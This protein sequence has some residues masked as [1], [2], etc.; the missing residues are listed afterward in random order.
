MAANRRKTHANESLHFS[1]N[2]DWLRKWLEIFKP[3][4]KRIKTHQY[5]A[6]ANVN[7]FRHSS[8]NSSRGRNR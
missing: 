5:K 8:E 2:S 4:V 7:Y 6:E 3:M 1:F